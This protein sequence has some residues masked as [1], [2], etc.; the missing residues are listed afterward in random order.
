M[1]SN[2]MTSSDDLQNTEIQEAEIIEPQSEQSS[3][4]VEILLSLENMIKNHIVSL[5]RL[6]EEIRKHR[7]MVD[8]AFENSETFKTH[9]ET[10]KEA[11]KVKNTTKQEILKQPATMQLNMKLK[12]MQS[13]Y[14]ERMQELSDLLPEYQRLSGANI[15]QTDDGQEREIVTSAKLVKRSTGKKK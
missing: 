14:K 1:Y 9:N 15:I 12:S 10:A 11:L 2:T 6:Q 5:E 7:E 4:G 3:G 13:E 8:S